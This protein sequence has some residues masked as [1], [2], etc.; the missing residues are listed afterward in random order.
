MAVKMAKK[1]LNYDALDALLQF[2]TTKKFCSDYLGIS[3]DTIERRLREDKDMTFTQYHELKMGRTGIKLQQK[4]I[5]QALS[6]N[7]TL[8]I[9]ALKNLAGWSDKIDQKLSGEVNSKVLILP[10]N[11]R[12]PDD[13][14]N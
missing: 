5:E 14:S 3:E 9:F 7:A 8:M 10:S 2:K 1:K 4:A 11:G 6:G 13:G 12:G